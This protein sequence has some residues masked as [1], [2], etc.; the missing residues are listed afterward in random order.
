VSVDV[1]GPDERRRLFRR[2]PGGL[3]PLAMW[4]GPGGLPKKA[5]GWEDTFAAAN[6]RIARAWADLPG[7][8]GAACGD[9]CPLWARPH[10]M[11]H[12]LSA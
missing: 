12:I 4:L 10:M 8:D 11:R 6:E 1:V 2:A 5:A 3:E 7:G 9:A